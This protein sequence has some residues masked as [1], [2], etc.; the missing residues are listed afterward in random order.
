M[1]VIPYPND[2]LTYKPIDEMKGKPLGV[3]AHCFVKNGQQGAIKKAYKKIVDIAIE[4]KTCFVLS[5]SQS[6]VLPNHN[7]LY[8]E[9]EDYDEF[10]DVQVKRTY[11]N[12]FYKWLDPIK[13]GPVSAEFTHI[14]C[15]T[16]QHPVN[17][18]PQ[19]A[20]VIVQSFM[21]KSDDKKEAREQLKK[22]VREIDQQE[23][24]IFANAH[25]S[26]NDPNHFLL[27]EIWS[28]FSD[29]IETELHGSSRSNLLQ[30]MNKIQSSEPLQSCTEVFQIYYDPE[31][32]QP[33]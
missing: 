6:L 20:Y 26:I 21:L 24:N 14:F 31:K 22:H 12:T 2:W 29:L 5:A 19:N 10:F 8:E 17:I 9:W 4:E 7:L 23:K 13:N 15:S 11:R 18:A 1:K 32:Y 33:Q 27:Y 25:Q 30:K 16:G 28:D 3:F